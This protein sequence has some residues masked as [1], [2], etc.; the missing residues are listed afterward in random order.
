VTLG[1]V[2][3]RI[4]EREKAGFTPGFVLCELYR[5]SNLLDTPYG[6]K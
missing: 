5:M 6:I 3:P 2:P 1:A 4:V